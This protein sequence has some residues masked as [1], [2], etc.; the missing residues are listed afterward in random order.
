VV[1]QL[2]HNPRPPDERKPAV[3]PWPQVPK[4]HKSS[5]AREEGVVE[6]WAREPVGFVGDDRGHVRSISA[7]TVEL[8]NDPDGGRLFVPVLGSEEQIPAALVLLA[9][10]FVGTDAIPL[11]EQLDV[12]LRPDTTAVLVDENWQTSTPGVFSCGDSQR[13]ASLV[14]WAI[15]DGR[16]CAASA[17]AYLTGRSDLPAPV[18]PS[19]RP[20]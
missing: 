13:G 2:D 12:E 18:T 3:N 1:H 16:A 15:A 10:G 9:P 11:V 4:V 19:S 17:H 6:G 8:R 7:V 20:L 5:P 14:A